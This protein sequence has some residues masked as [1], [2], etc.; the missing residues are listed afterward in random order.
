MQNWSALP[1]PFR[2][3][4]CLAFSW[5]FDLNN[6]SNSISSF[7]MT[8]N[9]FFII[10]SILLPVFKLFTNKNFVWSESPN[11]WFNFLFSK[12]AFRTE[13]VENS[14]IL[15]SLIQRSFFDLT[16]HKSRSLMELIKQNSFFAYK[17]DWQI[18]F[19]SYSFFLRIL[20]K[21]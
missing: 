1:G 14:R 11:S 20:P 3:K 18:F 5:T 16:L 4:L 13:I 10:V 17:L 9:R 8:K 15:F 19:K 6:I 12:M 21:A 7:E 2:F